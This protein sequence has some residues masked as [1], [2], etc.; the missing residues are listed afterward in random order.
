MKKDKISSLIIIMGILLSFFSTGIHAKTLTADVIVV[1]S[2]AAGMNA[3]VAAAKEGGK[4]IV[5]EKLPITGGTSNL[6]MAV[7]SPYK[8]NR[9]KVFR[10]IMD[11]THW[12]ANAGLVSAY[13]N[14]S[15]TNRESEYI[16]HL[17]IEI[18]LC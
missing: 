1:G 7:L 6:A 4:V 17:R 3:A 13:A 2:G 15:S 14:K 11:Y 5:F 12:R 9:D 8:E 16:P 10:E 18:P